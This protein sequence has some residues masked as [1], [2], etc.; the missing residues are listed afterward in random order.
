MGASGLALAS[1][2]SGFVLFWLNF[3]AYLDNGGI[4]PFTIK[5]VLLLIAIL[6]LFSWALWVSKNMLIKVFIS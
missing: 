1:S 5:K 3:R 4:N 6:T 2:L